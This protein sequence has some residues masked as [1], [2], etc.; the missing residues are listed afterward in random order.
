MR[1][2]LDLIIPGLFNLPLDVLDPAFLVNDLPALNQFL[3]YARP[4]S[5]QFF[6]LEPILSACMGWKNFPVLP[7]AQA[8]VDQDADDRHK[9]LL[10]SPVHLKTDM[11]NAIIAPITDNQTN[12][13]DINIAIHNNTNNIIFLWLI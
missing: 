5:N 8:Y 11:Y 3:Q 12:I 2:K 10:F 4:I 13:E 7:F 6:D 1:A 9:Y